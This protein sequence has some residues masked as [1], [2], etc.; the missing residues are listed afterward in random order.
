[1]DDEPEPTAKAFY[2]ILRTLPGGFF[3]EC[4][5]WHS[6]KV[7]SLPSAAGQ[8]LSKGNSFAGCHP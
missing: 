8:T 7:D 3:V 6:T 1:M 4:P 5:R 2:D